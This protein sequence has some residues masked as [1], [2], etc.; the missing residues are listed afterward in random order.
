MHELQET[1]ALDLHYGAELVTMEGRESGAGVGI[2]DKNGD[3]KDEELE[4][5]LK[6]VPNPHMILWEA[7][8]KT[9]AGSPDE[10]TR[11]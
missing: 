3:C 6:H 2:F 4:Q 5:V 9:A 11:P 1:V 10:F 8:Q 7:P